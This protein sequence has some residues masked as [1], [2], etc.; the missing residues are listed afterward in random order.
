MPSSARAGLSSFSPG[1][2]EIVPICRAIEG[3][4]A[5][6]DDEIGAPGIDVFAHPMKVV[7]QLRQPAGKMG[8]G[9]LGQAKFGHATFLPARLYILAEVGTMTSITSR[10][11]SC[12]H[13]RKRM[14]QYSR[15]VVME[16]RRCGVLDTRFRGYDDRSYVDAQ[17]TR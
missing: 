16:S 15:A 2:F 9:N 10:T 4:V 3:E 11:H 6:I 13:P 7:G 12:H 5:A 14:I 1:K 17:S 8:I